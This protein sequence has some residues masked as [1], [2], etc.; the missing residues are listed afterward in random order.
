[1][2]LAMIAVECILQVCRLLMIKLVECTSFIKPELPVCFPQPIS[3]AWVPED[4]II[5][6]RQ[7]GVQ[8]LLF[9]SRISFFS[10]S[11]ATLRDS[12]LNE[13]LRLNDRKCLLHKFRLYCV[14]IFMTVLAVCKKAEKF[15]IWKDL[16]DF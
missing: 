14:Y 13:M 11:K 3:C 6:L 2:P 16:C 8:P 7:T 12:P 5:G 15:Y 1:V 4:S 10:R 9:S